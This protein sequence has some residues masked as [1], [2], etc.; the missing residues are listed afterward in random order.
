MPN[1]TF[2]RKIK[3]LACYI[4]VY[5][6]THNPTHLCVY[7][8]ITEKPFTSKRKKGDVGMAKCF[9]KKYGNKGSASLPAYLCQVAYQHLMLHPY[10]TASRTIINI[11]LSY[12]ELGIGPSVASLVNGGLF[13][14]YAISFLS[15]KFS[16]FLAS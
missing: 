13:R 16:A 3:F 7:I 15:I 12:V 1:I 5:T 6:D 9:S 14:S 2:L 8:N 4:W 11:V 10:I